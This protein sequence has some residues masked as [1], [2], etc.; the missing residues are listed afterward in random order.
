MGIGNLY[1]RIR[2]MHLLALSVVVILFSPLLFGESPDQLGRAGYWLWAGLTAHD[3]PAG[4]DLYVFQGRV[5]THDGVSSYERLGLFPHPVLASKLVLVYR[6]EGQLPSPETAVSLFLDNAAR[7]QRHRVAVAGIQFDFDSPTARLQQY[8]VFLDSVRT[9]LPGH[10][11]LSVTGLGDWIQAES[12]EPLV[13]ISESVEEIVFQLY[14]GR[15]P[16]PNIDDYIAA[17]VDYPYPFRIG[18]V[19]LHAAPESIG[20]LRSNP[21][22]R[23]VTYFVLRSQ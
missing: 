5:F 17:L 15:Y 16:L 10:Y 18:L 7:W 1:S 13:R 14:Q 19:T 9:S 2:K 23:G 4:A 3:A 20:R 22:F 6:L 12:R 8:G 11:E 21:S